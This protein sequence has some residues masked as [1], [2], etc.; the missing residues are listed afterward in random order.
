LAHGEYDEAEEVL[1]AIIQ[2]DTK[3]VHERIK[4][5]TRLTVTSVFKEDFEKAKD[6]LKQ[7]KKLA[8]NFSIDMAK[9]NDLSRGKM[10]DQEFMQRYLD[11]LRQLGIPE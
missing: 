4:A 10:A 3:N 8:P 6:Y 1:S 11:A 9:A 5:L 7:L 2:S